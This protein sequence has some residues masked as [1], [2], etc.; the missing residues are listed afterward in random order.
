MRNQQI[1]QFRLVFVSLLTKST[2]FDLYKA[3]Y[4]GN[5]YQLVENW[6]KSK[7]LLEKKDKETND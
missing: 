4:S 1:S 5:T 3:V 2:G 7:N 6:N